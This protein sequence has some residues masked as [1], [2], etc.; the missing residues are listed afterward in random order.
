LPGASFTAEADCRSKRDSSD[1][2]VLLRGEFKSVDKICSFIGQEK[3]NVAM[4]CS[5][6]YVEFR[7]Q[8]LPL[9]HSLNEQIS[10][11]QGTQHVKKGKSF[12]RSTKNA[13]KI[14]SQIGSVT[15]TVL[16]FIPHPFAK[17]G[18][19]LVL[20]GTS[21][22]SYILQLID[23]SSAGTNRI[24]SPVFT[25]SNVQNLKLNTSADVFYL[26]NPWL[27]FANILRFQNIRSKFLRLR[28][29]VNQLLTLSYP[30]VSQLKNDNRPLSQSILDKL[31]GKPFVKHDSFDATTGI[32]SRTFI[33]A[34]PKKHFPIQ[35]YCIVSLSNRF[36][37][38]QGVVSVNS[39]TNNYLSCLKRIQNNEPLDKTCFG[40]PTIPG[41]YD[42]F[43]I[44]VDSYEVSV[45]RIIRPKLVY[46]SC[47]SDSQSWL[48]K[49]III[50]LASSSCLVQIDSNIIQHENPNVATNM[51][52]R[53]L[54]NMH[55]SYASQKE[56][57]LQQEED[58]T[59]LSEG[60]K[61]LIHDQNSTFHEEI[62]M[63]RVFDIGITSAFLVTA[64][65]LIVLFCKLATKKR[66]KND[67]SKENAIEMK[68]LLN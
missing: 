5:I 43:S 4:N 48:N 68:R 60:V 47:K 63:L 67:A 56:Y 30:I 57:L 24:A 53:L 39:T 27:D 33:W 49:G 32:L 45:I 51:T 15:S 17:V 46:V 37:I 59:K 7:D 19:Q 22:L 2:F 25:T 21:L 26:E 52:F 44:V 8:L 62:Y 13:V 54:V 65:A 18:S 64:F 6:E 3:I 20:G 14:I 61:G 58:F 50:I 42:I 11:L 23:A 55:F 31:Q 9:L 16:D 38:K 36:F 34:E 35:Q 66:P 12:K 1:S 40:S 29:Q 41:P 28:S 10:S